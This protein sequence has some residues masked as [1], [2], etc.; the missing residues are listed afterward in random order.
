MAR[1]RTVRTR[2]CFLRGSLALA[3]LGVLA[4]CGVLPSP[5]QPPATV[6]RIG[7][8]A[9]GGTGP[10]AREDAFRQGLGELG[11]VEGGN[12]AIEWRFTERNDS[13]S[14]LA[15]ELVRLQVAVIVAAGGPAVL[16]AKGA[17]SA[18]P[19]VMPLSGDP[20]AQG[21]VT[22]LARP[23]GNVTGLTTLSS[24]LARKRLQLLK[25][26]VPEASRVAVLW[27]PNSTAKVLGFQEAQ[28]AATALGLTLQSLEVRGR[29]DFAG[30]F[31]AAATGHVDALDTFTDPVTFAHLTPIVDFALKSRLPSMSQEREFVAAGGLVAYG[32]NTRDLYG[33]AA[34][35]VDKILKG[36]K[37]ADLP[38]E[39]PTTF[40]FVINL[41]TAQTLGLTFPQSI[42]LQ[43]TDVIQ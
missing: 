38:I 39:Q 19:I 37:P 4:G 25:E 41:K 16:A 15:A 14:D 33:R 22:S 34:T 40:D 12:L 20:V 1:D 6:P 10:G 7:Y 3:G 11:Y 36:A 26:I 9:S 29:D 27:N 43:A 23:G 21:Y 35:Y 13:L 8:L 24:E 30:A 5:V 28:V 17:T 31:E 18:I 32:P 42:M 2:R